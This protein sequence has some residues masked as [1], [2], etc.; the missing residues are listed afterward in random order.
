M[1]IVGNEIISEVPA[2]YLMQQER[3][4]EYLRRDVSGRVS[5]PVSWFVYHFRS[6]LNIFRGRFRS[7]DVPPW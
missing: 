1:Q 2:K 4:I 7:A 6:Q 5:D 3:G